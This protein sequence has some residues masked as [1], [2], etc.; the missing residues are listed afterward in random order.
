M[1]VVSQKK[2]I[3]VKTENIKSP[4]YAELLP[5]N[6][7]AIILGEKYVMGAYSIKELAEMVMGCLIKAESEGVAL[8]VMPTEKEAME[9][10]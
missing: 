3:A 8:F 1:I 9:D 10:W 6:E 4:E 7:W 5:G 2:K